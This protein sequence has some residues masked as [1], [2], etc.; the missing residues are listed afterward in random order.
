MGSSLAAKPVG[1]ESYIIRGSFAT[2]SEDLR[3]FENPTTAAALAD[4]L[5]AD[6]YTFPLAD[7]P[8]QKIL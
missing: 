6:R 8:S 4:S 1:Q 3:V 2:F 5:V 7:L